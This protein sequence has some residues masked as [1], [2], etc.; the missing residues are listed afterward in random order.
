MV[1]L[2]VKYS[3]MVKKG[4]AFPISMSFYSCKTAVSTKSV[5]KISEGY[6]FPTLRIRTQFDSKGFARMNLYGARTYVDKPTLE[7]F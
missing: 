1:V 7:D 5:E 4:F 3:S 6:H 2:N